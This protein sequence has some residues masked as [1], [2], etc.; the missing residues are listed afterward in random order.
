MLL[1]RKLTGLWILL[2]AAIAIGISARWVLAQD[3]GNSNFHHRVLSFHL[4]GPVSTALNDQCPD[5]DTCF[6]IAGNLTSR[7]TGSVYVVGIYQESGCETDG[8]QTC[9]NTAGSELAAFGA[10]AYR[11]Q[12][13]L[14]F[15]GST[16]SKSDSDENFSGQN[17]VLEG[18]TG[19]TGV[20]LVA[21]KGTQRL[22]YD[23]QTGDGTLS[24]E[25]HLLFRILNTGP[26][27]KCGGHVCHTKGCC[28][29]GC[30]IHI[31]CPRCPL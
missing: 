4:K 7:K 19:S 18:A 23:P 10:F 8:E 31:I 12:V 20:A 26:S 11:S 22:T 28:D 25:D 9:C 30:C 14:N 21:G 2:V 5:G 17:V 13:N 6:E 29:H 24:I 1:L 3:P 16:C 15:S 27:H